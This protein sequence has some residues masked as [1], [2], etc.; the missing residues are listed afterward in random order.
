M[1]SRAADGIP[2]D[3]ETM[4]RTIDRAL[5]LRSKPLEVEELEHLEA[6]LRG[7]LEPPVTG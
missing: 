7:H 4:R 3:V 6:L 1:N 2:A 5:V